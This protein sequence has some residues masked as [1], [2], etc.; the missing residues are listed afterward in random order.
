[1]PTFF[2]YYRHSVSSLI[3]CVLLGYC[4]ERDAFLA[5]ETKKELERAGNF[6]MKWRKQNKVVETH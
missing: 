6:C 5:R 1:M 4:I 3:L 2:P